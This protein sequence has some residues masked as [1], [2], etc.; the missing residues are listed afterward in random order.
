MARISF[1]AEN[2]F[3]SQFSNTFLSMLPMDIQGRSNQHQSWF[4]LQFFCLPTRLHFITWLHGDITCI[5]CHRLNTSVRIVLE[6]Q[7]HNCFSRFFCVSTQN[8]TESSS[9]FFAPS[10]NGFYIPQTLWLDIQCP[11]HFCSNKYLKITISN[12][13]FYLGRKLMRISVSWKFRQI[14]FHC[15]ND[16]GYKKTLRKQIKCK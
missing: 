5:S 8:W 4:V 16:N 15:T 3:V 7:R 12:H 11:V 2:I 6:L 9:I 13:A 1:I 14:F 10:A